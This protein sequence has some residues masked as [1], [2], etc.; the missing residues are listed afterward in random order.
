MCFIIGLNVS[1]SQKECMVLMATQLIMEAE[2][3]HEM[4]SSLSLFHILKHCSYL[5]NIN[6]K[7]LLGRK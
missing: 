4:D 1:C 6:Y 5:E 2:S 7:Y 3:F